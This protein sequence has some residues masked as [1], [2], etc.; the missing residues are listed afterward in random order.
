MFVTY[1]TAPV[2]LPGPV[3]SCSKL[4]LLPWTL[5]TVPGSAQAT[6]AA[7]DF[8]HE[9]ANLSSIAPG[10]E[11]C[12]NP[13]EYFLGQACFH[14]KTHLLSQVAAPPFLRDRSMTARGSRS[15]ADC[16]SSIVSFPR[17]M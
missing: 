5:A 1:P 6:A 14:L 8:L 10:L 3:V 11:R 13:D 16:C 17:T 9:T 15:A 7:H 12:W 4:D 2:F